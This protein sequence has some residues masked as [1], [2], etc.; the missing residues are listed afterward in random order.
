VCKKVGLCVCVCACIVQIVGA[1]RLT[2]T[3]ATLHAHL[4]LFAP[5]G[6]GMHNPP[7]PRRCH[8]LPH[9]PVAIGRIVFAVLLPTRAILLSSPPVPTLVPPVSEVEFDD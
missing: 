9:S 3:S 6:I 1:H 5:R 7:N 4:A 8:Q 2:A